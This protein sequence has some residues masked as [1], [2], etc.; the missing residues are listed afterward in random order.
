MVLSSPP[1]SMVLPVCDEATGERAAAGRRF[2]PEE[3]TE[4]LSRQEAGP[5]ATFYITAMK[6]ALSQ[7]ST[8]GRPLGAQAKTSRAKGTCR[9][10]VAGP[11][12]AAKRRT[13]AHPHAAG[14]DIGSKEHYVAVPPERDLNNVR[15]FSAYTEG[16]LEMAQWLRQCGVTTVAMESTGVYWLPVYQQL[17][18]AGFEVLLV[19]TRGV[20]HVPGRKSDVQDCQWLQ[21]LH[22]YGLLRG[23]F[24][25]EDLI[26]QLRSFLRHRKNLVEESSRHVLR[27][28]KMLQEMNVLVHHVLSDLT[29]ES[30]LRILDAILAGERQPEKLAA[31]ADAR[32]KKTPREIAA[33]LQGDYREPQLFVLEQE[34]KSYRHVQELIAECDQRILEQ[35]QELPAREEQKPAEMAAKAE[36]LAGAV[37]DQT[38]P[39]STKC[40]P[41]S[42]KFSSS[43]ELCLK[44]QLQRILGVDLTQVPGLG[45]LAVLIL[46]S[47]IGANMKRWRSAKAFSSWLGLSPGSKI[48]GGRVLSARTRKVPS[49]AATILRVAAKA[50]G[51]TDT[52]LGH[53]YRRKQAKLGAPKAIT[54]TARK[55][56]CL[57]YELI[58]TRQSY[59]PP[60]VVSYNLECRNKQIAALRKRATQLG[61]ELVDKPVAA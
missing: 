52:P 38:A 51:K 26:C 49:R 50:L 56:A 46:L 59:A 29:G 21:E 17:E 28:Q 55:L 23:A 47:E 2:H 39:K 33:A 16:L 34:L 25:P 9:Q 8:E 58:D 4:F 35:A 1:G 48:S 13:I 18:A 44:V 40:K 54:A 57:V 60:S 12:R 22:T 42:K 3:K 11:K 27:M 41:S 37:L 6:K 14:I 24:R 36:K 15:H 10:K 45:V 32:V 5:A 61:C 19:D 43:F 30:G 53:F 31:L 7:D 20:K